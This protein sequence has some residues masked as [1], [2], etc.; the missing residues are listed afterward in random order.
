MSFLGAMVMKSQLPENYAHISG[1]LTGVYIGGTPNMSSIQIAVGAD[2]SLFGALNLADVIL[3]GIYLVFLTSIAPKVF[4]YFLPERKQVFVENTAKSQQSSTLK[5]I[6]NY[7]YA[8]GFA[9]AAAGISAGLNFLFLGTIND[10]LFIILLTVF[11]VAASFIPITRKLTKASKLGDFLLLM[12][13]LA[14]GMLSDVSM[15]L[16]S[17]EPIFI[18]TGIVLF[19][20]VIL[21]LILAY[22]FKID[23]DT[24]L[25]TG[26]ACLYGPPFVGQVASVMNNRAILVGGMAMGV[27]GLAVG[28]LLGIAVA[29]I[30]SNFF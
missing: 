5:P 7:L 26:V 10:A 4:R 30:V 20:S 16:G 29:E 21:H 27:A 19:G 13:C 1:M 18:F 28:N 9:I 2:G 17:S 14:A 15:I 22:F 23:A 11:G 24:V 12:F 3:G 6:P 8:T 25:I